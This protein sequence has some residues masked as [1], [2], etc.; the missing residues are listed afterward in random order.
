MGRETVS[1]KSF[2]MGALA[3]GILAGLLASACCLG[4]LLLLLLGVSGAWIST[5]GRLEPYR[6]LFIAVALLALMMAGRRIWRPAACTPGDVC[7]RRVVS[8]AYK[9]VF[10]TVALLVLLALVFP[11]I[12]HWFY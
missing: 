11:F 4:P 12:A 3:T 10:L 6:P 7:A 2:T 8:R 1:K 9:L 5:L